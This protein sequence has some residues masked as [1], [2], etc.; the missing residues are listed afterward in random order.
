MVPKNCSYNYQIES[1]GIAMRKYHV[2]TYASLLKYIDEK[3][4][5]YGGNLSVRKFEN[6]RPL[7][8]SGQDKSTYHQLIFAKITLGGTRWREIYSS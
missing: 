3:N 5:K 6:E 8:I 7:L 4:K 1:S 2:D